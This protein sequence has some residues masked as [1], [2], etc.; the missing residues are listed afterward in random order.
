[1]I[2]LLDGGGRQ[3]FPAYAPAARIPVIAGCRISSDGSKIALIAGV[4]QQR[5]IFLERY[6]ISDYR[7]TYHEFLRGEAFRR[8]VHIAF[9]NNDT[10]VVFEQPETLGVFDVKTRT[11][12]ALPLS[13]KIEVMDESGADS[14]FFL[15]VSENGGHGA[16]KRLV[17]LNAAQNAKNTI[18]LS[19]PFTGETAFFARRENDLFIGGGMTL[20]A[21]RLDTM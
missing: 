8:E 2:E 7:V 3:V 18:L 14:F 4:D 12:S 16:G 20:A 15:V 19:V 17:A 21:F 10:K 1:M 9:I 5:F 11:R 6:G 13:G